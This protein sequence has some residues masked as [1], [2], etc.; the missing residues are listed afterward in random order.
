M[1]G[2]PPPET[3]LR[4]LAAEYKAPPATLKGIAWPNLASSPLREQGGNPARIR[5]LDRRQG[6]VRSAPR[7][8][9][10]P[11]HGTALI[12]NTLAIMQSSVVKKDE[13]CKVSRSQGKQES[14][15]VKNQKGDDRQAIAELH[16]SAI[17]SQWRDVLMAVAASI[18]DQGALLPS[19]DREEAMVGARQ[20]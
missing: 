12:A 7:F 19:P 9:S 15:K 2:S 14:G 16:A 1:E 13:L 5:R 6:A 11:R 3:D 18:A 10:N 17:G 8:A 20:H 4:R